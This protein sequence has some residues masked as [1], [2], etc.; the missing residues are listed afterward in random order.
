MEIFDHRGW[1][2]IFP[3]ETLE[4]YRL[5][6]AAGAEYVEVDVHILSDDSL[7]VIHD[8]TLDRTTTS[9]GLVSSLDVIGWSQLT[10]D[11]GNFLGPKWG[12]YKAPLLH[13]VLS[14]FGNK[15]KLLLEIKG[16]GVPCS[17]AV[18]KEL[19]RFGIT[20]E[21]VIINSFSEA[22]LIPF[23][24]AG[25]PT[26]LNLES[27]AGTP[28]P[29]NIKNSGH[30][31]VSVSE[32]SAIS[33]M[34]A[35]RS[36]GLKVVVYTLNSHNALLPFISHC[37]AVYTDDGAY[38]RGTAVTK[39]DPFKN[40]TW[41]HGQINGNYLGNNSGRGY[42]SPPDMWGYNMAANNLWAGCAQGWANP[43]I[44]SGVLSSVVIDF[45][46]KFESALTED[47]LAWLALL[48]SDQPFDNDVVGPANK[49]GYTFVCR[50]NGDMNIFRYSSGSEIATWLATGASPAISNGGSASY[51]ITVTA[52]TLKLERVGSG[53]SAT[54][55]DATHRGAFLHAGVKGV[56]A[57]FSGI[58]IS[59]AA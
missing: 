44:E 40:Q 42:F 58:T 41:F 8:D 33:Q 15:V 19:T 36:A 14:E 1:P 30:S 29:A 39:K 28:T 25:F 20:P 5:S 22:T 17:L 3:E 2:R 59:D 54:I 12:N 6:V 55:T 13:E 34:D 9:I 26:C 43:I 49:N 10:I 50:K 47:R 11:A 31:W 38:L 27:Y 35:L 23:I 56:H 21:M 57:L 52:S 24:T 53:T 45:T 18:L 48:T 7:V 32:G 37:D 46:I 16:G 51:R 4:A